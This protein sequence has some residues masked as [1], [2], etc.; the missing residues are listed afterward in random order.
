MIGLATPMGLLHFGH[1]ILLLMLFWFWRKLF[2]QANQ[3]PTSLPLLNFEVKNWAIEI[4]WAKIT[5]QASS[6]TDVAEHVIPRVVYAL[7]FF[8]SIERLKSATRIRNDDGEENDWMVMIN[9]DGD[10]HSHAGDEDG[11]VI[12]EYGVKWCYWQMY[13]N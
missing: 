5:S 7:L 3:E 13:R 4:W 10:G 2:L 11:E 6:T 1:Q 8:G 12:D 9:A